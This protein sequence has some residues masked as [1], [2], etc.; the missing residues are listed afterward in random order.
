MDQKNSINIIIAGD[1][2][3]SDQH[4]QK[5][6][7]DSEIQKIFHKA[8][9]RILNLEAPLTR[10][11]EGNK[12]LKTGPSLRMHPDNALSFLKQLKV[13]SVTLSNNHILDYG[14][15][16]LLDTLDNLTKSNIIFVGAGK[17]I[18][19]AVKP[20]ILEKKGFSIALL[21]FAENEWTIAD[22]NNMGASPLDIIDNISQIK[23]LKKRYDKVI[24]IIHGGNE[25]YNLPN[26]QMQKQYRFYIDNGAD[27]IIGHH[28]H[29]IGGYEIYNNCPIIYSLGNFIFTM[30]SKFDGWYKGLLTYLKIQKNKPIN[31]EFYPIKQEKDSYNLTIQEGNDAQETIEFVESLNKIIKSSDKI[32]K[33]W[34]EFIKQ[35]KNDYINAL[36]VKNA[37]DNR[38]IRK[39]IQITGLGQTLGVNYSKTLLNL[40][41]CE[42]H[43]RVLIRVLSSY[44]K[45]KQ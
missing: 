25:H 14:N 31:F 4:Y 13:D 12:I 34:D 35:K 20:L 19:E 38:T 11:I 7:I 10:D 45:D 28:P 44:I 33:H 32:S 26:P 3:I 15:T 9:Y 2:Y 23:T 5:N 42:A 21:N 17:N 18:N 36:S 24:C 27:A 43:H 41:R 22:E 37:F 6:L 29:C 1:F 40:L 39:L 16:G 30:N 8:D